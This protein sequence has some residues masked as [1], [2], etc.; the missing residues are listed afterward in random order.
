MK[1]CAFKRQ[2]DMWHNL[3]V[4][5]DAQP[6]RDFITKHFDGVFLKE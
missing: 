3:K 2:E 6:I 4:S 5:K 1:E